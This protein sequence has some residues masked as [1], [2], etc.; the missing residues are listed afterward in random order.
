MRSLLIGGLV[1]ADMT[2]VAIGACAAWASSACIASVLGIDQQVILWSFFGACIGLALAPGASFGK[3]LAVFVF[4][5]LACALGGTLL[6]HVW[7]KDDPLWRNGLGCVLA[8][9][10]HPAL[11]A[12]INVV[13]SLIRGLAA[14][15]GARNE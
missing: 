13:P 7:H 12:F 3:T 2:T 8:M 11:S 15:A 10:F 1:V 9:V 5:T 6:S 14:K 4:V